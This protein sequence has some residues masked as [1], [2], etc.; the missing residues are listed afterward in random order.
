MDYRYIVE[1]IDKANNGCNLLS[2]YSCKLNKDLHTVKELRQFDYIKTLPH[3]IFGRV[4]AFEVFNP[5]KNQL[6]YFLHVKKILSRELKFKVTNN[7]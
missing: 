1:H 3:N 2:G 5:I 7:Y 4:I 6:N